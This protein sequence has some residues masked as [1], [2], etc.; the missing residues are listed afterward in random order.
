MKTPSGDVDPTA[1]AL[2]RLSFWVPPKRMGEFEIAY[3]KKIVPILKTHSLLG[4]SERGRTT[5]EEVFSRLFEMKT[6][7]EVT[8]KE[9]ALLKDPAFEEVLRSLGAT[10]GTTGP[11]DLIRYHFGIYTSPAGSG[12]SVKAGAGVRQRSWH[13]FDASDGLPASWTKDILQDREGNL[14]IACGGGVTRYDGE[15]FV[16][17]TTEDGLPSNSVLSILEDREGNLWFGTRGGVSRYDGK[18]FVNFTVEDGLANNK[19]MSILED[20]EGNLWFGAAQHDEEA[21]EGLSRYDGKGFITFTTED[22]LVDN[23]VVSLFEDRE[24]DLWFGTWG[25][26]VSRYDGEEFVTFAMEDGL[27]DNWVNSILED[28]EGNLWFGTREGVSK[29]DGKEF[30][31]FAKEDGFVDD[32]VMSI[33]EDR[34]GNL[35]FGTRGGVSK[36]DGKE[37]VNFTPRD[38]LASV[39]VMSI[40]E[41]RSG[42][43]W[44]GT[45]G[46][47]SRYEGK[48]IRIFTTEY[49]LANNAVVSVLED[50][51]GNL[52]F[53]TLGGGVSR[54]DGKEFVTFAV[55]DGLACDDV[56]TILEDRSGGLWFGTRGGGVSRYDGENFVTFTEEDGLA[57]NVVQ[58]ILEDPEGYLWF[59]AQRGISRYDGK[60][61]VTFT[62][63]SVSWGHAIATMVQ[64]RGGDLWLGVWGSHGLSRYDGK[65][66]VTFTKEDGLV[67]G[68]VDAILEDREGNLWFGSFT[69]GVS[70]YDGERFEKLTTEEGLAYNQVTSI[71][72]DREGDLW[73]GTF[74]GGVSRYDGLVF[75][76]LGRRDGLVNNTIHEMIQDRNGDFWITTEGGVIQYRSRHTP[77]RIRFT[78]VVADRGYGPV[79]EIRVPV[80]QEFVT[81]EFQGSDLDTPP[82]QMVYVYRLGGYDEKWG[83]TQEQ[84]VRYTNLPRGEYVFQVKAVDQDLN[85][86]EEPA[87]VRVTVVPDPRDEQIDELERR[88]RERTQELEETH[89][90]LEE[91][92]ARLIEGLEK[93]LQVAHDVQ[94]GLLPKADPDLPGFDI[95]GKC[96]PANHV[97]G[98][99]YTYIWLDEERTK[100]AI[101]IADV[102][103]K[104]MKAAMTVMRFSEMLRYET[105]GRHSPGEILAGLNRS[106]WGQLERRMYVTAC[107]GVLDV[108][109]G[110]LEVSNA[111]HPKVYHLSGGNGSIEELE[112]YGHLLGVSQD[113]EYESAKVEV[114]EGDVLVFY[115]DG[116]VEARDGEG[117]LYGFDRLEGV[118]RDAGRDISA[119]EMMDR[120]LGEVERF[121]GTSQHEDDMTLVVVRAM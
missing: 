36:Y 76:K 11:D 26:G 39:G 51:S 103:G 79:D 86:S 6:P 80:S 20:Q 63:S 87:T 111:G 102:S 88:V 7:A 119:R 85:Y 91:T 21:D 28:R 17:F 22:G 61:F 75:Q 92:Q 10:F 71:L 14:W 118:I 109:A 38:G 34:E 15:E 52:W 60:E 73:F 12:K 19:V 30:V 33:L 49:G 37:F 95:V 83:W 69:D 3:E 53:G 112:A 50:R 35:W 117:R 65:E 57:G 43:L 115:T 18:E 113:A 54:Y 104:E 120:I 72:E 56:W 59:G 67:G 82:D 96:I 84:K 105:Q 46:G 47:A 114:G 98:D 62:D 58:A 116:I 27:A 5:V 107:V 78:D 40:F 16:I 2:A 93:E 68:T 42:N 4:S 106:V 45:M 99:H 100:F 44:F 74:G 48:R 110:C 55:E 24:G 25:G 1:P 108:S 31:T 81:F 41:D 29:Y 101:I 13:T 70:R 94:M 8:E 121:T 23:S 66:F 9:N 32:Y 90:Q 89:R 77:P 64:D 97:G